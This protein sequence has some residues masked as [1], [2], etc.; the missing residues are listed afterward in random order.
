V[1]PER[2]RLPH[3]YRQRIP[4]PPD[5]EVV[6]E[7][8]AAFARLAPAQAAELGRWPAVERTFASPALPTA[9][10][11]ASASSGRVA[12]AV[13]LPLLR[14]NGK[15]DE[16]DLVL[17]RRGSHLRSNPGEI[18]FPGGRLEPGESPLEAALREAHEEVGLP[19]SSVRLLGTLPL[20]IRAS[21]PEPIAAFVGVVA[22]VPILTPNPEEVDDVLVTALAGLA[23]PSLYWEEI[24]RRGGTVWRMSFF[25]RGEDL[26]WGASARILVS[27]LD[28]MVAANH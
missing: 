10:G 5:V 7:P 21:R 15:T 3:E 13:L 11:T 25:D 1:T 9:S 20:A 27:L 2:R 17:I 16:V 6:D 23:D 28:R 14:G 26:M 19:P 18:A 12:A 4:R 8:E 22:D 24:W